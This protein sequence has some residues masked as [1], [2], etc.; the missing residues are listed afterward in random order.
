MGVSGWSTWILEDG[1]V[2]IDG[3]EGIDEYTKNM[4]EPVIYGGGY[5]KGKFDKRDKENR[6]Y[7]NKKGELNV[8]VLDNTRP[9]EY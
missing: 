1:T 3:T 9:N 5:V 2:V 6:T 7:Y 4:Y 8:S